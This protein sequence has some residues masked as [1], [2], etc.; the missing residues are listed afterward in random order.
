MS[1]TFNKKFV[2]EIKD[3]LSIAKERVITSINIAMVYS[4]YEIGRRIVMEEQKGKRR[5]NYGKEILEML[6]KELT[7]EFGRGYSVTNLRMIRKFYLVYKQDRIQ[8]PVVAE[9]KDKVFIKRGSNSTTT[10]YG[11]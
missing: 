4:Y 2:N 6:S 10:G 8:Q 9:S 7:K 5:A 3:I 1:N 11:I